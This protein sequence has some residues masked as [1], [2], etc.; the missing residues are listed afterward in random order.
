MNRV[1]DVVLICVMCMGGYYASTAYD[2]G[3]KHSAKVSSG[4]LAQAAE[5]GFITGAAVTQAM[6]NIATKKAQKAQE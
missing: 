5:Q 2:R 6:C 4:E 1:L 3:V